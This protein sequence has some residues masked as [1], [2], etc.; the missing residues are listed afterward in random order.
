VE[1]LSIDELHP[2][3]DRVIEVSQL[4]ALGFYQ[5]QISD[6]LGDGTIDDLL[7][8]GTIDDLLGDGTLD[9]FLTDGF[10]DTLLATVFGFD[11]E[12]DGERPAV[13]VS[14]VTEP[15]RNFAG[16]D[17]FG[18]GETAHTTAIR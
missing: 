12:V 3:D 8:Y 6:F 5:D 4:D 1:V 15:D 18:P 11:P 16:G 7:R 10:D 9:G 17:E 13:Y 14:T 2:P